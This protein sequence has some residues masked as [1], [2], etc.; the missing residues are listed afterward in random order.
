MFGVFIVKLVSYSFSRASYTRDELSRHSASIVA[1]SKGIEYKAIL[2]GEFRG[3][4]AGARTDRSI[5][6]LL[7]GDGAAGL[8]YAGLEL[9]QIVRMQITFMLAPSLY[10]NPTQ[11][12]PMLRSGSAKRNE[13]A[14]AGLNPV[15]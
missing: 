13:S 7:D 9:A 2:H 14:P 1:L 15:T 12:L 4:R 11:Q 10:L 8:I 3:V 6:F 5:R